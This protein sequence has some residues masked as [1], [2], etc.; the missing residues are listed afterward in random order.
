MSL[1]AGHLPKNG[2]GVQYKIEVSN[3]NDREL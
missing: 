2:F 1:K 3:L